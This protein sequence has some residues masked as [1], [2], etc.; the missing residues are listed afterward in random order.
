M[1]L[2][3]LTL[4]YE[5]SDWA[6]DIILAKA[7]EL[8][9]EQFTAKPPGSLPSIQEIAT[10]MLWGET[11]WGD[12]LTNETTTQ[13]FKP[14][15]FATVEALQAGWG[16]V[17][18]RRQAFFATLDDEKLQQPVHFERR[19][20]QVSAILWH[21]LFQLVNHGTQHRSE[22]ATILTDYDHS[23]G[24][25]DFFFFVLRTDKAVQH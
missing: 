1:R 10:H 23:P 17:R 9:P 15:S 18:Q 19:G 13:G 6:N 4:L 25:L 3:E 16:K 24:D 7:A 2:A 8:T 22:I 5:F 12:R 21:V 20:A 14:D 11:I